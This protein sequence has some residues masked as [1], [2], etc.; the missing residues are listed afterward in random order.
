M[1]IQQSTITL[2]PTAMRYLLYILLHSQSRRTR[3]YMR[4]GS[5][6]NGR[7]KQFFFLGQMIWDRHVY[8]VNKVSF[9]IYVFACVYACGLIN[10]DLLAC[11]HPNVY[12]VYVRMPTWQKREG[13]FT[14]KLMSI[15]VKS[16]HCNVWIWD[17]G[18]YHIRLVLNRMWIMTF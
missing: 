2:T 15:S 12:I 9:T 7:N 10:L 8:I 3:I 18:T 6:H 11:V 17:R 13:Q 4:H 5:S 16:G 1:P 14:I